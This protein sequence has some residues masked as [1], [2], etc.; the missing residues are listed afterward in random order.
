MTVEIRKDIFDEDLAAELL[1]EEVDVAPDD[2]AQIE[3]NGLL[4]RLE[5]VEELSQRPGGKNL[6]ADRSTLGPRWFGI[7]SPRRK[8]I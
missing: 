7:A 6:V 4:S 3:Q 5:T 8:T 1:A 2:R